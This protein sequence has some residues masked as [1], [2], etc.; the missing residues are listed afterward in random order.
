M[1]KTTFHIVFK[2]HLDI[3]FTDFARNVEKQYLE[4]FVPRALDLADELNSGRRDK[5]F[6]WTIG[7]WMVNRCL[8]TYTGRLLKRLENALAGGDITWHALPF[9]THSELLTPSLFEFG[10]SISQLLDE[11]FDRKTLAAKLT[12]VPGHT[13]GIVPL[14]ADAG[15]R[16]LHIGSNPGST[17]PDVPELFRWREPES[18]TEITV[19]YQPGG[20]GKMF[21]RPGCDAGLLVSF[22]EDNLGP[23]A[24]A[25]IDAA[26]DA[27]RNRYPDAAVKASS[28]DAFYS[29]MEKQAIRMPVVEKEMGDTWIHGAGTAPGKMRRFRE[30]CRLRDD[31]L[32]AG[33]PRKHRKRF[34]SFSEN[35]LLTGEHTW[36]LD[37]K[38]HLGDDEAYAPKD[39]KT[40]RR[41]KNFRKM[42]ASWAEQESYIDR[43]VAALEGA[44]QHSAALAALAG[45][46][47]YKPDF[48][49]FHRIASGPVTFDNDYYEAAYDMETGAVNRLYLKKPGVNIAGKSNTLG[50]FSYFYYG[51]GDYERFL[52]RYGYRNAFRMDWFPRDFGK[53]GLGDTL[54]R[55]GGAT[56][57]LKKAFINNERESPEE[58]VELLFE[59]TWPDGIPPGPGFPGKLYILWKLHH[60]AARIQQEI[61]WFDK[62]AARIPESM[63]TGFSPAG[64]DPASVRIEKTGRWISPLDVVRN[65]NRK[66]HATNGGVVMNCRGMGVRITSRDAPL[67]APGSPS[68][69]DFNNRRPALKR[70]AHFNLFNNVWGT[71]F[72]QWTAEDARFRFTIDFG[73]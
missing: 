50:A 66:L 72:P 25:G 61:L 20:Y 60:T 23:P 33:V 7:S 45:S 56:A 32:D 12:D 62:P 38:T 47:P 65:G 5:R 40:A 15:V 30:L 4:T 43:A 55:G 8:E 69:L 58:P 37:V 27:V 64:I 34:L 18:G 31:W 13:L 54:T 21:L 2:T 39:F 73:A 35:L 44:P 11:R 3:G 71:N 36:G 16:F 6:V 28:F 49:R 24:A 41:R 59:M 10:L 57:R 63:W 68:L 26:F 9:T 1:S 51:A 29:R 46:E 67:V 42:E 53:P 19:M 48:S 70:G 22:T 17:P 14:L 52:R